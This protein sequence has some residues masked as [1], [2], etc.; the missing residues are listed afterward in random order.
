[1]LRDW[2]DYELEQHGRLTHP[3]RYAPSTDKYVACRWQEAF[4]AIGAHLRD[5]DPKSAVFYASG[6]ASLETSYMY[7]LMARKRG[8]IHIINRDGLI[9]RAGPSYGFAEAE[10]E[11][12]IK[13]PTGRRRLNQRHALAP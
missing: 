9:A 12:L 4:D 8:A 11:R 2:T 13:P 7:G 3:L 5:L 6:R 1:M 10:Y